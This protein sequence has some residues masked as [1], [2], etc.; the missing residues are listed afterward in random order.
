MGEHKKVSM[1]KVFESR[2]REKFKLNPELIR[3]LLPGGTPEDQIALI[4]SSKRSSNKVGPKQA[5]P[6]CYKKG[7]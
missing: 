7:L 5:G 2:W 1:E 6:Q 4:A 3:E